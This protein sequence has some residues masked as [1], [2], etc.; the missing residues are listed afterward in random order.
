MPLVGITALYLQT[1]KNH[2]NLNTIM[3]QMKGME[4]ALKVIVVAVVVLVAALVVLTVFMGGISNVG[5]A[6]T[7]F[8]S[9]VDPTK[10]R[11][12]I[13]SGLAC[14]TP[15]DTCCTAGQ[16]CTQTTG[17]GGAATVICK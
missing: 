16:V 9:G 14:K 2:L 7:D 11:G 6:I 1:F 12:C 5:K 15:F 3:A 10:P 13:E 8:L 4:L 17:T